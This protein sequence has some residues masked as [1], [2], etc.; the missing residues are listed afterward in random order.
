MSVQAP[1]DSYFKKSNRWDLF[2][3]VVFRVSLVISVT[4][5]FL[6]TKYEK[7][8]LNIINNGVLIL[9][10]ILLFIAEN[11]EDG[12]RSEGDRVRRRELIGNS[13]KKPYNDD[14]SIEYYNNDEIDS[15]LYKLITNLFESCFWSLEVSSRMKDKELIKS[16]IIGGVLILIAIYG[17][18]NSLIAIPILQLFLSKDIIARY[19]TINN[20]N[21]EVS[22]IF[23]EVKS[24][25]REHSDVSTNKEHII[26]DILLRYECN[27][28]GSKITLRSK[29]FS[30]KKKKYIQEHKEL[31]EKWNKIKREY[32]IR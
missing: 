25:F 29:I 6:S 18:G 26:I 30:S 1:Q 23:D 7:L 20:Y 5:T 11:Q 32:N 21:K 28:A 31:E 4:L 24:L 13:F 16:L 8:D 27:I 15:G 10:L 17:L 22:N 19:L 9:S 12:N 2:R 14:S 3:K